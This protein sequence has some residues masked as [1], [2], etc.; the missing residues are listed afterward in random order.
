MESSGP[1][2]SSAGSDDSYGCHDGLDE[3]P[4]LIEGEIKR[5]GGAYA[6]TI[7]VGS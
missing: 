7:W 2:G 5:E 4:R 3:G 1:K 6:I